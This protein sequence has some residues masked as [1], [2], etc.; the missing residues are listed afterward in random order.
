MSFSF[1]YE[2]EDESLEEKEFREQMY[3]AMGSMGSYFS[4]SIN[5]K[6]LFLSLL[7]TVIILGVT[8]I[9]FILIYLAEKFEPNSFWQ[10]FFITASAGICLFL[11]NQLFLLLGAKSLSALIILLIV[12]S[13]TS[14]LVSYFSSGILQAYL[15]NLAVGFML[16]LA[17]EVAFIK[18]VKKIKAAIKQNSPAED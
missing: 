8:G 16:V 12:A 17:L 15:I 11:L 2:K 4:F 5:W 14:F 1:I 9:G 7:F 3:E 13:L 6:S 18:G 10:S